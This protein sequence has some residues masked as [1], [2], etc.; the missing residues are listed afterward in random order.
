MSM[1][2]KFNKV[3]EEGKPIG[4]IAFSQQEIKDEIIIKERN[5]HQLWMT[6]I[7]V[8]MIIIIVFYIM[9]AENINQIKIDGLTFYG[10]IFSVIILAFF[11]ATSVVNWKK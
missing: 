1:F 5:K 4:Q 10:Y 11:G 9:F 7:S 3:D 8:I 2:D 6:W